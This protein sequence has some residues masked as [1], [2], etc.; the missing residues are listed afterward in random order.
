MSDY[1]QSFWTEEVSEEQPQGGGRD[2]EP[3]AKTMEG[4]E[5]VV[6]VS[7]QE[8]QDSRSAAALFLASRDSS[9]EDRSDQQDTAYLL[10]SRHSNT[11]LA[12]S[13]SGRN[14]KSVIAS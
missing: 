10:F 4:E 2:S 14:R 3:E 7:G 13:E 6:L 8:G 5:E 9:H 12:T 1:N 11:I